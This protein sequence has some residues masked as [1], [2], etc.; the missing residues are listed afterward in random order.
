MSQ[1]VSQTTPDKNNF[2]KIIFVQIHQVQ[3]IKK[4]NYM[5]TVTVAGFTSGS[6]EGK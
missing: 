5:I 6:N 2:Y 4:K 3:I 1:D